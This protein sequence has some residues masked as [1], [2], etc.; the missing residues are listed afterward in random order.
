MTPQNGTRCDS[1][2]PRP[3]TRRCSAPANLNLSSFRSNV[4]RHTT[5]TSLLQLRSTYFVLVDENI[6]LKDLQITPMMAIP[7]KKLRDALRVN[8]SPQP[9]TTKRRKGRL[10]DT[11]CGS[12]RLT[13][14]TA[15]DL[16]A[17]RNAQGNVHHKNN[18]DNGNARQRRR[19]NRTSCYRRVLQETCARRLLSRHQKGNPGRS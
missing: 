6:K 5:K 11:N 10:A 17:G 4:R 19:E 15:E 7:S 18:H 12:D 8:N 9:K 16:V 13:G 14:L 2:K 1:S 3:K